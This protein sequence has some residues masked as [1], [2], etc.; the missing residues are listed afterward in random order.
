M[1]KTYALIGYVRVTDPLEVDKHLRFKRREL[2][3]HMLRTIF[4]AQFDVDSSH[5]QRTAGSNM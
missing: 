3:R 4:T 2:L 1:R 5:C